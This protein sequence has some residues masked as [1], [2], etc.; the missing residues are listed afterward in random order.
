MK[1]CGRC[2]QLKLLAEFFR[3]RDRKDGYR[4]YCKKCDTNAIRECRQRNPERY[5]QLD[6]LR[7]KRFRSKHP[8]AQMDYH[9]RSC[10]GISFAQ[11]ESMRA[12]QK[13]LCAICKLPPRGRMGK[14]VLQVDHNHTTGKVRRLICDPCNRG[15][16]NFND[17]PERLRK[18]A[19]YLE[20]N[21]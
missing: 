5:Q 11:V 14:G 2:R 7:K 9:F 8:T 12:E 1:T 20:E 16:G 3:A 4:P 6:K 15:L 17:D 19:Q 10:Y 13:G 18:A 21:P